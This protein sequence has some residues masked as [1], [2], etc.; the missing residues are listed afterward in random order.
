MTTVTKPLTETNV[1]GY[2]N[3]NNFPISISSD[4]LG[5]NTQVAPKSY[6]VDREGRKINDP[7]LDY[8]TRVNGLLSKEFSEKPVPVILL[9]G[10]P[11]APASGASGVGARA[12]SAPSIPVKAVLNPNSLPASPSAAKTIM[13]RLPSVQP[14]NQSQ[15]APPQ[16]ASIRAMTVAEGVKS[17]VISRPDLRDHFA[18]LPKEDMD[19]VAARTAP[20]IDKLAPLTRPIIP[21]NLK[22]N[23]ADISHLSDLEAPDA[24]A[25][26][27]ASIAQDAGVTLPPSKS[28]PPTNNP[29]DLSV[30]AITDEGGVKYDGKIFKRPGPFKRMLNAKFKDKALADEAYEM[31]KPQFAALK[32]S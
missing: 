27:T 7:R 6:V 15:S 21:Q 9:G 23:T 14:M 16:V 13:S 8:Y 2:K 4:Q 19:G 10:S 5:I 29:S 22:L 12:P 17:G 26:T 25:A 24:V 11:V 28:V 3:N 20:Y 18:S 32:K 1:L 30:T 31:F